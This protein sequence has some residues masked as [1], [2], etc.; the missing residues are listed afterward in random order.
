M[1]TSYS[2]EDAYEKGGHSLD[3]EYGI[4][5]SKLDLWVDCFIL[6]LIERKDDLYRIE[7]NKGEIELMPPFKAWKNLG[8]T[9]TEAYEAF[10]QSDNEF[11]SY[12]KEKREQLLLN[13]EVSAQRHKFY[14]VGENKVAL[15]MK[16]SLL[17]FESEEFKNPNVQDLIRKEC[18]FLRQN[19]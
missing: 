2:I 8:T 12:L 14:G 4:Y 13:T 19:Q 11:V 10:E 9:R 16:S 6:G 15:Y 18:D 1:F 17:D 5:V 3:S 7:Y